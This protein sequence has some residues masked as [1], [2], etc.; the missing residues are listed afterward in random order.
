[1]PKITFSQFVAGTM[2]WGQWGKELSLK[3]MANLIEYY[4]DKGVTT[5]DHADIYG[6]YSMESDFGAAFKRASVARQQVQF[7]TKCGIQY[8]SENRNNEVVHY[9]TS[10]AY[11]I[12]SVEASLQKLQTDYLDVLLIHRPSPLMHPDE[13]FEAVEILKKEGKI[14][15]FGVSNFLPT[16]L[17][18][19][20]SRGAVEV[21]QIEFS[22][23]Q[24]GA[25][26]DGTLDKMIQHQILPMTWGPVRSYFDLKDTQ[27]K[28]RLYHQISALVD[29]YHCTED[30][31]LY[32]WILK[33]PAGVRPIIGSTDKDR[34]ASAVVAANI[35][36][37]TEDWFKILIASQ[38][39]NV[40]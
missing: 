23:V 1:M 10:K 37:S 3:S 29:S 11:I 40:P 4:Y 6:S 27:Q 19:M 32:A 16:Q 9:D 35:E 34:I 36:L 31:L 7:V 33:H 20:L 39:H 15:H 5:F 22:V 25:L 13:I 18:L 14:L 26:F 30:Q 8:I 24:Y 21:N 38:G 17:D 2:S 28:K 12:D